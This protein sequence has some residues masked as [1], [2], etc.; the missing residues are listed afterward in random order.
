[1]NKRLYP[2]FDA[3]G[4]GVAAASGNTPPPADPSPG[5]GTETTPPVKPS[6]EDV[7]KDEAY[8]SALAA[9][10]DAAIQAAKSQW[11][12]DAAEAARLAQLTD[13]ERTAEA[14][15]KAKAAFE[16]EKSAFA[17]ERALHETTLLLA[18]AGLP[19][20]FAAQLTGTDKAASAANVSNFKAAFTACN[21]CK[22]AI[23]LRYFCN[24]NYCTVILKRVSRDYI[25]NGEK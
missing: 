17:R 1:M 22:S 3:D 13:A 14:E 2:C 7:Q 10:T 11:D 8:A 18:E 20:T 12:A 21:F 9:H 16:E 24:Y 4:G 5:N 15:K 19:V 6:W 25:L 23:D